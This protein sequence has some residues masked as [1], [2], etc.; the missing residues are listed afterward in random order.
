MFGSLAAVLLES[1]GEN[2]RRRMRFPLAAELDGVGGAL[3]VG[4]LGMALV[5]IAGAVALQTPG[6]SRFR[7]DIQRSTILAELNERVPAVGPDP[8]RAGAL[9][10]GSADRRARC[11]TS[12]ARRAGS[13][14]TPTCGTR[15]RAW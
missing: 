4:A 2:L 7:K 11:P 9:R 3:L 15:D 6:A 13:C 14:A 5:W 12:R 8:Q 10:P 1:V